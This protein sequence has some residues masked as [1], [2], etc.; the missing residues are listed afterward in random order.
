L[1]HQL[2]VQ[3]INNLSEFREI[4]EPYKA[5][6]KDPIVKASYTR[7]E[8]NFIGDT[9]YIGKSSYNFSLPDSNGRIY[10]MKDFKGKIVFIDV[11]ATWCGPCKGEFPYLKEIEA[12]YHGN[13]DIVFVGISIDMASARKKWMN[14]IKTEGL[15]GIQLLDD[16][17]KTF[18]KK[19][20]IVSIPRFLLIDREGNWIEI[21]CPRPSSKED[22][23]RL[24]DRALK[25]GSMA[26]N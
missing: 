17:G 16:R 26:T 21:K 12:E 18:G 24:L 4:F 11:W 5:L 10:S 8:D 3:E 20:D 2:D 15:G 7:V 19:Y 25:Q 9:I 1:K 23:K 14:M 13:K 6:A 22:L